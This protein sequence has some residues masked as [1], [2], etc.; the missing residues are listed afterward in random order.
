MRMTKE[1]LVTL[2]RLALRDDSNIG[3]V[4]FALYQLMAEKGS[5]PWAGNTKVGDLLGCARQTVGRA[6]AALRLAGLVRFDG[7][8]YAVL[9]IPVTPSTPS[10]AQPALPADIAS[11]VG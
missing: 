5:G 9:P 2:T 10:P 4:A 3:V 11:K 1:E 6:C 7:N 8:A